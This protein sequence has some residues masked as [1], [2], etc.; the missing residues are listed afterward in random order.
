[1]VEAV[2]D[3]Y[4]AAGADIVE[5]NTFTATGISQSDYD[6]EAYVREMNVEAAKIA[7]RSADKFHGP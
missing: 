4:L 1:M 3:A 5:T 6:L 7:R 2:H